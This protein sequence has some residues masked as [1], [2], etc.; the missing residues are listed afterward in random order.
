MHLNQKYQSMFLLLPIWTYNR[1][2]Y[3]Y[4]FGGAQLHS[5]SFDISCSDV[6]MTTEFI[7]VTIDQKL[8]NEG[9]VEAF[10]KL[11]FILHHSF[12]FLMKGKLNLWIDKERICWGFLKMNHSVYIILS[13]FFGTIAYKSEMKSLNFSFRN[14]FFLQSLEPLS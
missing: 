14:G 8:T 7:F 9:F 6:D 4:I 10:W 3:L 2:L 12:I 5:I 1:Y 13:Y 11:W